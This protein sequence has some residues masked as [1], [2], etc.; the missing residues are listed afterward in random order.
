M[1]DISREYSLAQ[2]E[3]NKVNGF[4]LKSKKM[5]YCK[6]ENAVASIIMLKLNATSFILRFRIYLSEDI[7]LY[8][9]YIYFFFN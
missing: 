2:N 6:N 4:D 8:L 5:P 9:A 3:E 1:S 7:V